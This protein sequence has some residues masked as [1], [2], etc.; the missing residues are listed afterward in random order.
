MLFFTLFDPDSVKLIKTF[1]IFMYPGQRKRFR[2]KKL[3]LV[4]GQVWTDLMA[5]VRKNDE[6]ESYENDNRSNDSVS[7]TKCPID[8]N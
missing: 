4:K 3:N 1:P 7:F 6:R 2:Q 5:S 8:I